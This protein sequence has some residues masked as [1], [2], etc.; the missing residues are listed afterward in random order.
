MYSFPT[1]RVKIL[2]PFSSRIA[3]QTNH[4]APPRSVRSRYTCFSLSHKWL[5]IAEGNMCDYQETENRSIPY[6]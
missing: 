5:Q 1:T 6:R 2:M 4:Q 3:L